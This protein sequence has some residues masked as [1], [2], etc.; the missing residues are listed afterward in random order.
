MTTQR[1]Y[2]VKVGALLL[3]T[4][5][6]DGSA[7]EVRTALIKDDGMPTTISVYRHVLK[8]S[9]GIHRAEY[10]DVSRVTHLG[11]T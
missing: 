7:R 6:R 1:K 8:H 5:I 2:D 4:V 10:D 11:E 3:G 9:P